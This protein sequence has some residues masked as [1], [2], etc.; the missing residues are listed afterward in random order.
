MIPECP[1]NGWI[2]PIVQ[3]NI[4]FMGL[5]EIRQPN[6]F[7]TCLFGVIQIIYSYNSPKFILQNHAISKGILGLIVL[8]LIN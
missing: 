8:M 1:S 4:S 7:L 2:T 6:R 5:H 3:K